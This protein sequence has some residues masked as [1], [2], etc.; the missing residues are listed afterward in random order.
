MYT[1]GIKVDIG[2]EE[3][4]NDDRAMAGTLLVEDGT[5]TGQIPEDYISAIVCDGVGGLADGYKASSLTLEKCK[6]LQKPGTTPDEI[7]ALIEECNR[8]IIEKRT[9]EGTTGMMTT[10]AGIYADADHFYVYNAGDSRVYRQR[11]RYLM[12]LSKDHSLVQDLVDLGEITPEEARTHERKNVITK[13]LGYADVCNPR[14]VDLEGDLAPGDLIMICS[15]GIYDDLEDAE[16]RDILRKHKN[17]EQLDACC[18][19]LY[20]LAI[21]HGS[22]DNLSV[23][24]VRKE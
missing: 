9:A 17:D 5:V 22:K 11:H 2:V 15:D 21:A 10:I 23:V 24:V 12:L 4:R 7:L 16:I 18:E 14:I 6:V 8:A 3:H 13:C 20:S 1:Y 19:E